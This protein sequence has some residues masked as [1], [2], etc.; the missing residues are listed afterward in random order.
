MVFSG[1]IPYMILISLGSNFGAARYLE[2]VFHEKTAT[3]AK[4]NNL[5]ILAAG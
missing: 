1:G 4:T 5:R 2:L 3:A